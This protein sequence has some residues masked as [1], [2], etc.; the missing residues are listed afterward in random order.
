MNILR[1]LS[2][3]GCGIAVLLSILYSVSYAQTNLPAEAN[4][5]NERTNN[6]I[7]NNLD[8]KRGKEIRVEEVDKIIIEGQYDPENLPKK[9]KTTKQI[10]D[11]VLPPI[12]DGSP[13]YSGMTANGGMSTEGVRYTCMKQC[14][15]PLC[16]TT[17][18]G[19]RTYL[20]PDTEHK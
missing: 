2:I 13:S 11:S 7:L 6:I 14:V 10:F 3:I 12:D 20:K 9:K 8:V 16:C 17:S 4:A 5:K 18:G 19:A 1:N 15:G